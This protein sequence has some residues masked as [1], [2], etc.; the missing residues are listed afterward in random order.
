MPTRLGVHSIRFSKEFFV[1]VAET[2]KWMEDRGYKTRSYLEFEGAIEYPLLAKNRFTETIFQNYQLDAG[3][4]G[5]VGFLKEDQET[6]F[7]NILDSGELTLVG[8]KEEE[9]LEVLE[10]AYLKQFDLFKAIL[11]MIISLSEPEKK[12]KDVIVNSLTAVVGKTTAEITKLKSKLNTSISKRKSTEL[13]VGEGE[14]KVSMYVPIFKAEDEDDEEERIVFGEV[15]VPDEF[16]SEEDIY[17]A[18]EIRKAAHFWMENYGS[19]GLMHETLIDNQV[20]IL[21]SFLAPVMF[22]I[23]KSDGTKRK[24]KKGTW[25]LKVR[26]NDDDLWEQAK[27]EELTGFSIGGVAQVEDLTDDEG[28]D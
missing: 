2:A 14:C 5:L 22:T 21:E 19:I 6:D 7:D 3:V 9:E 26:I 24:I 13:E 17:S 23:T 1:G 4:I 16:D 10:E 25:L 20:S 11:E 8:E 15:L 27:D 18:E 12:V 28:E